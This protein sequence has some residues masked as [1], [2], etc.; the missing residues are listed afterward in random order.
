[1]RGLSAA[2]TEELVMS[3]PMEKIRELLEECAGAGLIED[4][5]ECPGVPRFDI[6]LTETSLVTN[7]TIQIEVIGG[8]TA[9]IH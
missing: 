2:T 1:V 7:K 8:S 6:W 5:A 4:Y 9:L 3:T